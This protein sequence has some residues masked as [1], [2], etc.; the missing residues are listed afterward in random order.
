MA[1]L[2]RDLSLCLTRSSQERGLRASAENREADLRALL[3]EVEGVLH[4]QAGSQ[5]ELAATRDW[6]RRYRE[7]KA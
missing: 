4:K 5:D 3:E 1:E 7:S 6:L 2:E